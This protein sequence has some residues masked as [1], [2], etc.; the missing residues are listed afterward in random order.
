MSIKTRFMK[1]EDAADQASDN[2]RATRIK[3]D[4]RG[5][6]VYAWQNDRA[7]CDDK[8]AEQ[9]R[10]SELDRPDLSLIDGQ[11]PQEQS[12]VE[13]NPHGLKR[14]YNP[15]ESGLLEKQQWKRSKD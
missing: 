14:G 8:Y 3:F 2:D 12:G 13:R 11:P 15:Y 6:A 7:Y 4:D 9:L 10:Q 5:N 1:G